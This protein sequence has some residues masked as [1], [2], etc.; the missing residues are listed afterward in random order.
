MKKNTKTTK[1]HEKQTDSAIEVHYFHYE[2]P[3]GFLL[4][5]HD[6]N[7]LIGIQFCQEPMKPFS[8]EQN[9]NPQNVAFSYID[10]RHSPNAPLAKVIEQL[11]EYF[12]GK[13][14][15]F[16][17]PIA[18]QHGT[19]FQKKVWKALSTIPFGETWSYKQL[20]V[21]IGHP[22][23]FRAVG[24]ANHHNPIPIIIPCHRVIG[25][26]GKLVGFGGGLD[27][28]ASLLALEANRNM[29]I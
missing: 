9:K 2:S 23:A 4:L 19:L 15:K 29:T 17:V 18:I 24:L 6:K 7:A 13:R 14:S 22:T 28:K 1:K 8:T 12:E 5:F 21:K 20:A 26:N 3:I 27:T 11:D 25:S 16:T 10:H